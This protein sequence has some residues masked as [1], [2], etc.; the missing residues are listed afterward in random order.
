MKTLFLASLLIVSTS[1]ASISI[2]SGEMEQR[3]AEEIS[4]FLGFTA[5]DGRYPNALT[6]CAKNKETGAYDYFIELSKYIASDEFTSQTDEQK[7]EDIFISRLA[8][9][10]TC[11]E[12]I[13]AAGIDL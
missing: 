1:F 2:P 7:E 4:N 6:K 12:Q 5:I 13:E 3:L 10:M 11:A 8:V 9:K